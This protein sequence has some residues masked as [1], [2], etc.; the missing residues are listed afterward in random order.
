MISLPFIFL[1]PHNSTPSHFSSQSLYNIPPLSTNSAPS[2][3]TTFA[4]LGKANLQR[5]VNLLSRS[6]IKSPSKSRADFHSKSELVAIRMVD[7]N[8]YGRFR[9]INAPAFV[10]HRS[11]P[12]GSLHHIVIN[13]AQLTRRKST[14]QT[15]VIHYVVRHL[16]SRI[17]FWFPREID[18]KTVWV[19]RCV[20]AA[21]VIGPGV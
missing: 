9:F 1:R 2:F 21:I 12:A 10:Q 17:A 13:L 11:L 16:F 7:C 19:F 8:T 18:I 3:I 6:K 15:V 4:P 5:R 20:V 14:L